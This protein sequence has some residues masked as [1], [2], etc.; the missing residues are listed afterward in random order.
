M[1]YG[2]TLLKAGMNEE[3]ASQYDKAWNSNPS[4]PLPLYLKGV[5]IEKLGKEEEAKKIKRTASIMATGEVTKRHFLANAMWEN[6][7]DE[8]AR[9]Q[10]QIILKI[11]SPKESVHPEALRRQYVDHTLNSKNLSTRLKSLEFYM[12]SKMRPVNANSV[13]SPRNTLRYLVD[14]EITKAKIEISNGKPSKAQ[15]RMEKLQEINSSDSSMLEDIYQLLV[16][17]ENEEGA[18]KIFET[19]ISDAGCGSSTLLNSA[20]FGNSSTFATFTNGIFG[21]NTNSLDCFFNT[22]NTFRP[23]KSNINNF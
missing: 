21:F 19:T 5:A 23:W 17:A 8:L 14:S 7:D 2:D 3:A 18:N 20:E 11:A 9:T 10:D 6:N 16:N 13:L 15:E 22:S 12:L 4:E 1:K